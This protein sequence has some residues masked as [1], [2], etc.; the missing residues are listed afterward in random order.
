MLAKLR[1]R[2]DLASPSVS[3][4]LSSRLAHPV[5]ADK[6]SKN[7]TNKWKHRFGLGADVMCEQAEKEARE[8]MEMGGSITD[9]NC[10]LCWL[11]QT[12]KAIK[13]NQ[14][15]YVHHNTLDR[16]N[17]YN[18]AKACEDQMDKKVCNPINY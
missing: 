18:F 8:V 1:N 2:Q 3:G 16:R 17:K 13:E 11:S 6:H 12:G 9:F 14:R 15:S 10:N 7:S 5:E 4:L